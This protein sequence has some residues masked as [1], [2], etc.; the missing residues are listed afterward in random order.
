MNKLKPKD[1]PYY[2]ATIQALQYGHAGF[3]MLSSWTGAF[4]GGLL[5]LLMSFAVALAASKINDIAKARK[6]SSWLIF[7]VLM[8]V[9]PAFVGVGMWMALDKIPFPFW[10]LVVAALWGLIP[11]GSV[12]LVGFITGKGLV[13]ASDQP[14][15]STGE[16]APKKGRTAKSKSKM[17]QQ[18]N[19]PYC[20]RPG[21]LGAIN[22]HKGKCAKNPANQFVAAARS[23]R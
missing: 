15:S 19:C 18:T 2:A 1:Y 16:A 12:A 7:L 6:L 20:S 3:V 17:A 23:D 4:F 8:I 10:R 9:S 5:G 21:T 14:A 13:A 11:D 22:A